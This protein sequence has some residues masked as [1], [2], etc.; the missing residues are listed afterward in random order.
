MPCPHF[1]IAITKRS[2]GQS[3]V[4]GSAYQSGE[5]LRSERDNKVKDYSRKKGIYYTQVMLPANAP[6]EYADRETLWNSVEKIEGQWNSQLARRIVAAL[7]RE[8]PRYQLPELVQ[9]YCRENFV[10]KGM[11]VDFAIHDPAPPGH[12]PHVHIMLTLRAMDEN[13]KWL[14][15]AHKVYDLD[16]N[17]SRIRL[18][19]G[20]WK[21]HK[22]NTV[23]W[24][25]Q[26][27]AEEWRHSWEVY[28]N[29][30]LERNH[31][32]ERVDMRSFER[33]GLETAPTVHMGPAASAM[34]RKGIRTDVGDLNRE[35][36]QANC[37]REWNGGRSRIF[38]KSSYSSLT[39]GNWN[40]QNGKATAA[41]KRLTKKMRRNWKR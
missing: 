29:R 25:E 22:E 37:G 23:D 32:T 28:Q 18:P 35:I 10:E 6:P 21:S 31:R 34:E 12:N 27:H 36:R 15:K 3:A 30:Y 8:I 2:N 26:Y 20:S 5:R 40:G 7:P 14:P 4:A 24:N 19:S 11:C 13:G 33:Q 9:E 17:G 38:W 41:G 16:E 1:D 39:T